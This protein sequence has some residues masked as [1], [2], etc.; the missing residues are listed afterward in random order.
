MIACKGH[1]VEKGMLLTCMRWYLAYPLSDRYLEARMAERGV[2]VDHSTI[3]LGVQK[4]T[5]QLEATYRNG[6]KRPV[7]KSRRMDETY[8]K[9]QGQWKYLYRPLIRR[10]KRLIF[11]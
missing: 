8:I 6:E 9:I 5:P 10:D 4:F 1:C 2:P 11:C 7:E 3:Y